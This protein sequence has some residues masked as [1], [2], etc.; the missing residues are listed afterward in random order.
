METTAQIDLNE[1]EARQDDVLRQLT[2]LEDQLIA[3]IKET[4][5]KI[6]RFGVEKTAA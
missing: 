3:V 5:L 1:L 4:Q 2:E 6:A